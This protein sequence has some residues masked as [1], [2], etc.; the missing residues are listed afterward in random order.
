MGGA[1]R[2]SGIAGVVVGVI[3]VVALATTTASLI[4]SNTNSALAADASKPGVGSEGAGGG[5]KNSAQDQGSDDRAGAGV[6][7][8]GAD[9]ASESGSG[10][11]PGQTNPPNAPGTPPGQGAPPS[12]EP[13]KQKTPSQPD[14]QKT[15][16]EDRGR[17]PDRSHERDGR[18]QERRE[19]ERE[20]RDHQP[21]DLDRER[22]RREHEGR[23]QDREHR[24]HERRDKDREHREHEKKHHEHKK[25]HH[26]HEKKHHEKDGKDKKKK[27]HGGGGGDSGGSQEETGFFVPG[28]GVPYLTWLGPRLG[29]FVGKNFGSSQIYEQSTIFDDDITA[30]QLFQDPLMG[31]G[32][33][34]YAFAPWN[35][36][37]LFDPFVSMVYRPQTMNQTFPGGTFL[38]TTTNWSGTLGMRA[39]Y[40]WRPDFFIYGLVGASVLNENIK[41][42]LGGPVTSS[43]VYDPGFTLGVGF[44]VQPPWLQQTGLP[45]SLFVELQQTWWSS[46]TIYK[47]AASPLF[48]Y[49][50]DRQDTSIIAGVSVS[51]WP[52]RPSF[53]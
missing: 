6:Q 1:S 49:T 15:P 31:G 48:N 25:K 28:A 19:H 53:K 9:G 37:W 32:M 47:P 17:L 20:K 45:V 43:N 26:E 30:F 14:K 10:A 3:G 18:D 38:G 11:P 24:E 50:F 16:H 21:G 23:D 4:Y 22:E 27:G 52:T 40:L 5:G 39:G 2:A 41:I 33:L 42:N 13:G 36:N 51:L 29:L 46:V 7:P 44:S 35:N 34:D 12:N 8:S